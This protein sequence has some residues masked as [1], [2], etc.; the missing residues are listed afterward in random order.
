M[1]GKPGPEVFDVARQIS[2]LS[3]VELQILFKGASLWDRETLMAYKRAAERTGLSIPSLAGVWGPNVS[4][5]KPGPAEEDLRKAIEAAESLG[6]GKVINNA[7]YMTRG[8]LIAVMGQ[9]SCY[10]GKEI[11]WEQISASDFRFTPEPEECGR[12]MELI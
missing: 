9:I 10:T 7:D 5:L 4:I 2:G 6:A 3:G 11:T 1:T 12:D 8:T